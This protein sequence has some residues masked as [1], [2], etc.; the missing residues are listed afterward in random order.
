MPQALLLA[1]LAHVLTLCMRRTPA[2][3]ALESLEAPKA[4]SGDKGKR[5]GSKAKAKGKKKEGEAE[6]AGEGEGEE[7]DGEETVNVEVRGVGV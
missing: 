2:D 1:K 3:A 6:A 7:S 4:D 5:D